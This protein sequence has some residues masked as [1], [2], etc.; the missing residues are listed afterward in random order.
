[1]RRIV[2][3]AGLLLLL[4]LPAAA[5]DPP[6]AEVFGG[7]Q[8]TRVNPGEGAEGINLNGWNAALQ[9]NL[10]NWFGIVADFSGAYG[11]PTITGLGDVDTNIHTFL[12]GPQFNHRR[13]RLNLF[14][15]ALFG[16]VRAKA[17][18]SGASVSDNAFGMAIGGGVDV[19]A[20]DRVAIRVVQ[21][22]YVLTRFDGLSG[23]TESQHNARISGGIVFRFGSR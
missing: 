7:Y 10:N 23:S 5:Q 21:V 13:D 1:M 2:S 16:A 12:F 15:R 22:D 9:G 19:N 18:Q 17:T 11:T 14:T 4:T 8:Y 20:T 3:L 6:K